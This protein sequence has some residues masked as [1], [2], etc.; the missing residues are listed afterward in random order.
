[1]LNCVPCSCSCSVYSANSAFLNTSPH[2]PCASLAHPADWDD[3]ALYNHETPSSNLGHHAQ[4]PLASESFAAG[5]RQSPSNEGAEAARS[6]SIWTDDVKRHVRYGL[7]N[8]ERSA[9]L[10][11]AAQAQVAQRMRPN[12]VSPQDQGNPYE[13]DL[14]D[15]SNAATARDHLYPNRNNIHLDKKARE[16]S[17][18]LS[19]KPPQYPILPLYSPEVHRQPQTNRESSTIADGQV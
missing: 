1:M 17:S 4:T 3:S 7:A 2:A 5:H 13:D 6:T 10:A 11:L 12:L 15:V 14:E 19:I 8:Q 18:R 9:E 16:D